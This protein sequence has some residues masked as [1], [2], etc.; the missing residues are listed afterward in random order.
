[1][2]TPDIEPTKLLKLRRDA[3]TRLKSGS[4]P[5]SLGWSL[6]ANALNLIHRLA[7][8]PASAPDALKLLHEVQVHQVELDLQHEQIETTQRELGE[9]LAHYQE[10]YEHT[11]VACLTLGPRRDILECNGAAADLFGTGRDEVLGRDFESCIAAPRRTSI[12]Q[13]LDGLVPDGPSESCETPIV[14]ANA[15]RNLQLVARL[16]SGGRISLVLVP[17]LARVE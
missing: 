4:A 16:R 11:P 3:E 1:M 14:T 15:E 9:D 6:G 13:F 12:Q 10:L 5:T 8:S 2:S 17:G 7:S